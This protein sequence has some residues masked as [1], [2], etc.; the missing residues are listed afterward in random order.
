MTSSWGQLLL[1]LEHNGND[2]LKPRQNSSSFH[3]NEQDY[4]IGRWKCGGSQ[5]AQ[6][7]FV[8]FAVL[9]QKLI[10]S[11]ATSGQEQMVVRISDLSGGTE[12]IV[13][14]SIYKSMKMRPTVM[15]EYAEQV[16]EGLR[17]TSFFGSD[18]DQLILEGEESDESQKQNG[19]NGAIIKHI[20]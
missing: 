4:V 19:N 15:D 14:G 13:V 5:Y 7:Y 2:L 18:E 6:M 12:C 9:N 16:E 17:S 10:A 20:T 8:R 3:H 11:L 1:P